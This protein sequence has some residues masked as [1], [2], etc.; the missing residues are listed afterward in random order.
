MGKVEEERD[1][2]EKNPSRKRVGDCTKANVLI[3]MGLQEKES[4]TGP[5][6]GN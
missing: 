4:K 5:K 6:N 1:E 3:F 2:E